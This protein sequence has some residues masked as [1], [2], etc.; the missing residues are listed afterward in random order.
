MDEFIDQLLKDQG[1]PGSVPD[2]V[3]QQLKSDLT[4][5]LVDMINQRMVET[6][7]EDALKKFED[8][9]D[10][11]PDDTAMMQAFIDE[12]VPEKEQIAARTMLEFR[13]LYLGKDAL[14]E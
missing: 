3:Y 11:H 4:N 6:L 2:D 8:I 12:N 13:T 7:S 5:R 14:A 1:V 9:L 10:N